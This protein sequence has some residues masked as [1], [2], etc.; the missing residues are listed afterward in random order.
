MALDIVSLVSII[1]GGISIAGIVTYVRSSCSHLS[2]LWGA[3]EMD[4]TYFSNN[5]TITI[6]KNIKHKAHH[7][8]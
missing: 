2:C 7:H 5:N 1:V 4:D 3:F 6:N 8:I